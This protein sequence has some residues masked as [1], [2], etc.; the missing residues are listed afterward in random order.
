MSI[1][2]LTM[3][4]A[5]DL[6]TSLERLFP[7]HKLRCGAVRH[8]AGGGGINVAR[9]VRR[10]GGEPVAIFPSGGPMGQLLERL[11]RAEAV[12]FLAIPVSG[13]TREDITVDERASGAQYRFVLPGP[14]ISLQESTAC[15]GAVSEILRPSDWLVASG[16]LPPGVSASFYTEVARMTA[17]KGCKFVLDSSGPGLKAA[18]GSGVHMIKPSLREFIELVGAPLVD[19]AAYIAAA[20][21][22]IAN[23]GTEVIALT[24]GEKGAL[25]IGADFALSAAALGVTPVSTVGA[26]DCFLGAL[27]FSLAQGKTPRESLRRGRNCGAAVAGHRSL[28]RRRG[29]AAVA[30]S[31]SEGALAAYGAA[32]IGSRA[33]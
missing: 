11:V 30:R 4:P 19:E 8:D 6:S 26:G 31:R 27:V 15:L 7:A 9:V 13:D 16:S 23:G 17:S 2:T 33:G 1:I 14:T 32:L 20:R 5:V 21:G 22:I 24:L 18:L 29:R 12:E 28:S 25:L 3:N 10:L